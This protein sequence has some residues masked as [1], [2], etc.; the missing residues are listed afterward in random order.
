MSSLPEGQVFKITRYMVNPTIGH[1][2]VVHSFFQSPSSIGGVYAL[3]SSSFVAQKKIRN[4]NVY[5][6]RN[7]VPRKF[8]PIKNLVSIS[9]PLKIYSGFLWIK[10][11]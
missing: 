7:R 11:E 2:T 1:K 8:H 9:I 10:Q 6:L 4:M 5:V 3:D